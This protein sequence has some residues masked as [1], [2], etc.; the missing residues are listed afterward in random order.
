MIF[1][2]DLTRL[3]RRHAF[4]FAD[5]DIGDVKQEKRYLEEGFVDFFKEMYKE[6]SGEVGVLLGPMD[7][8]R[9]INIFLNRMK[10]VD[11]ATWGDRFHAIMVVLLYRINLVILRNND[12]HEMVLENLVYRCT[13]FRRLLADGNE[14]AE[15]VR[16]A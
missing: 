4:G 10:N 5:G 1:R 2:K 13:C 9:Q 8:E 15:Y 14:Y 3:L 11:E 7:T 6:N 12:E 16:T